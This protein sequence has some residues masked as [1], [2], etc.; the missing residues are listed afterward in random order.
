[1]GA[2]KA[3]GGDLERLT[4]PSDPKSRRHTPLMLAHLIPDP[5]VIRALLAAGASVSTENNLGEAAL[6]CLPQDPTSSLECVKLLVSYGADVNHRDSRGSAPILRGAQYKLLDVVEFLLSAG[7]DIY[8]R[9][10]VSHMV[11]QGTNFF[12]FLARSDYPNERSIYERNGDERVAQL[13]ETYVFS[14]PD[15]EKKRRVVDVGNLLG[16]TLLHN[17]AKRNMPRCT[18][19]LLRQNAPVNALHE[20]F[21]Y[22]PGTRIKLTVWYETPLDSVLAVKA[23]RERHMSLHREWSVEEYNRIT[24]VSNDIIKMLSRAGGKTTPKAA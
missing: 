20:F 23:I 5:K 14:S 19:A 13:L 18:E 21:I 17:F 16:E 10:Y 6:H 12:S 9:D 2:I 11:D 15:E 1:M 22:S 24:E 3:L 8:E 4:T 7:A